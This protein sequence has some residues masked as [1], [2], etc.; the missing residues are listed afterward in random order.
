VVAVETKRRIRKL[1]ANFT[2]GCQARPFFHN[3]Q[4][5]GLVGFISLKPALNRRGNLGWEARP[6]YKSKLPPYEMASFGGGR[7]D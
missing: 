5:A 7:H 6:I 3:P 4:P 2:E 1:V